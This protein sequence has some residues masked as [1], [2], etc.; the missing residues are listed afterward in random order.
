MDLGRLLRRE[1][2]SVAWRRQVGGVLWSIVPDDE[3]GLIGEERDPAARTAS[4]FRVR[5]A[6]GETLW[7]GVTAPGGWWTG[8]ECVT[9]GALLLHGFAAPDLPGHRGLTALDLRDGSSLW[10]DDELVFVA[11]VDGVV[12]GLRARS[13]RRELIGRNL[14]AGGDASVEAAHETRLQDLVKRWRAE[15]QPPVA[16][17]EPAD[18]GS[19][20]Y[21]RARRLLAGAPVE[22]G[23]L[24]ALRRGGITIVA[25]HES[26]PPLTPGRPLFRRVLSI[27]RAGTATPA[28][29]EVLDDDLPMPAPGAFVVIDRTVLFVQGR[30]TLCAVHLPDAAGRG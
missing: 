17:P 15:A 30:R 22:E 23:R 9:R 11:V 5:I 21:A 8:I 27:F 2:F 6:T 25:H 7:S 12:Y 13:D 10:S 3:G 14:I 28:Y 16:V 18:A 26:G 19:D 29:R 1:T 20:T 24:E 4:F